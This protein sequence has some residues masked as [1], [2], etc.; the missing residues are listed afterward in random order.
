LSTARH[1]YPVTANSILLRLV[2]R[3]RPASIPLD[4][5]LVEEFT[6]SQVTSMDANSRKA[7]WAIAI[8][9][10]ASAII[11]TVFMVGVQ[12]FVD[13]EI[14]PMFDQLMKPLPSTPR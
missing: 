12:H 5:L 14:G 11:L 7:M 13:S 8:I 1:A 3:R 2:A 6:S 9:M 4:E 10:V